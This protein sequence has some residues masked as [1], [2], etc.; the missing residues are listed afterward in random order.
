MPPRNRGSSMDTGVS[1]GSASVSTTLGQGKAPNPFA[2]PSAS[3][4]AGS[5]RAA[6]K[7]PASAAGAYAPPR[8]EG[9]KPRWLDPSLDAAAGL[10]SAAFKDGALGRK[11]HGM[12]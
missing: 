6:A 2:F 11:K 10:H 9:P 5:R 4:L 7:K 12:R 3:G 1:K 8:D